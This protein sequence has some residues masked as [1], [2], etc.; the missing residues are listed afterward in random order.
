MTDDMDV[1]P[2]L[3]V[4]QQQQEHASADGA[5]LAGLQAHPSWATPA[6]P[7]CAC[8]RWWPGAAGNGVW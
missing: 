7:R 2:Q 3:G 4:T 6:G 8:G 5:Q 1:E